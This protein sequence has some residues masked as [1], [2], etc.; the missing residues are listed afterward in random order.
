MPHLHRPPTHIT[1]WS[2]IEPGL[3]AMDTATPPPATES[4]GYHY[5]RLYSKFLCLAIFALIFVGGMVKSTE[6]GLA[7]PDWPT[8]FGYGMFE[9][10]YSMM[11]GGVV[12]EHGHR[13]FAAVVGILTFILGLWIPMVEKRDWLRLLGFI[14]CVVVVLLGLLGG[15]T[16]KLKLPIAVSTLHGVLA[17]LYLIVSIM[18]AY[19]LSRERAL[20]VAERPTVE[21]VRLGR[22]S[23]WVIAA[24]FLQLILG[25]LMRHSESGLAIPDFPS[26]GGTWLP[27]FNE[28]WMNSVNSLRADL[29]LPP[30]TMFQASIHLAHRLGALLVVAAIVLLH[31]RMNPL[32]QQFHKASIT[33]RMLDAALALQLILA[34]Y[35]I[36]SHRNPVITS[37]HVAVGALM[38]GITTLCA[39]RSFPVN[40]LAPT[41][42]T[43]STPAQPVTSAITVSKFSLYLQQTKPRIVQM[44][45]VTATLGYFLAK[46]R[47][48][49][50][51]GLLAMLVGTGLSAAGSAALNNFL[52]RD[53]DARMKRTR[54][55]ALPSGQIEPAAALAFG[56]V[57][58]LLG[59]TI[60]LVAVNMLAALLTL[61]TAFLYV[62]VYTPLKRLTWL[63]TS[64][65]AI[66][67]ALPPMIGWAGSTGSLDIG[68]WILFLILFAWQHPHFYAIAWLYREDYRQG[69]FQMLSVVD[70][71]G[72]RCF[73]HA[74]IFTVGL[75]LVS[76]LLA[77]TGHAGVVYALG[78]VLIGIYMLASCLGLLNTGT[79]A[80]A[81]KV[82]IASVIYLPLLLLF[83]L[84]DAGFTRLFLD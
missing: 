49:S 28:A 81:R 45:L 24:L 17:Q 44:V 80:D 71:T 5:L 76:L 51:L 79:E 35:T 33:L 67:G 57:L 56:I 64:I 41:P 37:L 55:R 40:M 72:R 13:Q 53:V 34:A 19:S 14:A 2:R 21:A 43:P 84:A 39:L 42:S 18:I 66:P 32:R 73:R 54:H 60:N 1:D 7:V 16:V 75:V 59:V 3:S 11:K 70:P 52:E 10:P 82:L 31:I 62:L 38:F 25:A 68:A 29:Q 36:W 65:G 8:S 15:L 50:W 46:G 12:Y 69:G 6:S 58:V 77:T 61:V 30:V 22:A 4:A 20:R 47:I 23:L 74:L 9:M 48:S 26:M 83:I 78:A 63:N 27:A